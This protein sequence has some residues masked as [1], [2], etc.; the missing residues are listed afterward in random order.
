MKT[1]HIARTED[2]WRDGQKA[3]EILA[4]IAAQLQGDL[5]E[6][7][8]QILV[9]HVMK[10]PRT[11]LLAHLD[12]NLTA[13]QV[14]QVNEAAG[15]LLA[16]IPLPY[17]IGHW[18]FFGLDFEITGDVLIPRPETELLVEKAILWL[19]ASPE[20][21]TIADVGT[22]SG[23]IAT[24][25]AMHVPGAHILATDISHGAL[26]VAQ[27]NAKKFNVR[28]HIDF[29]Q[30]D[31]LPQHVDPLPT[32]SHFDLICANLPYIPTKKLHSL[33]IFGREPQIALDGGKDGLDLYRRLFRLA[34]DWLAPGG[35]MLLEVEAT[36]GPQTLSL[37]YDAFSEDIILH[38]H[39]DLAGRDRLL[40]V[41]LP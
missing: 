24:T 16:G 26:I 11:W 40:E 20:R 30:C 25:L 13:P 38:L 4:N 6:L 33:P 2:A 29:L 12:T 28:Q 17:I 39:Q 35:M 31:L 1:P 32:E 34:P 23:V 3:A 19:Q 7:D 10:R 18:D 36:L 41:M 22:G 27:R 15:R 21:R 8:A 9:A 37:A 14:A 5:P